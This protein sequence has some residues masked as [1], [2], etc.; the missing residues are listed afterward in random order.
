MKD[1]LS[2][3]PWK[4]SVQSRTR[5][6]RFQMRLVQ[7]VDGGGHCSDEIDDALVLNPI[8]ESVTERCHKRKGRVKSVQPSWVDIR[9][10]Y[11]AIVVKFNFHP[12]YGVDSVPYFQEVTRNGVIAL[13][14][15]YFAVEIRAGLETQIAAVEIPDVVDFQPITGKGQTIRDKGRGVDLDHVLDSETRAQVLFAHTTPRSDQRVIPIFAINPFADD[16]TEVVNR[17]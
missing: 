10:G 3:A 8:Q 4:R 9:S 15:T 13:I 11:I 17:W 6:F 5:R 1:P 14:G 7:G 12:R 2:I 16:F